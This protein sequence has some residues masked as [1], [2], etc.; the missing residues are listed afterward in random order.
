MV[1]SWKLA[2]ISMWYQRLD[3]EEAIKL[4]CDHFTWD[5]LWEAATEL[6]QHCAARSMSKKI[7]K[8]QDQ[9]DQK[10]RVKIL[11]DGVIN[12]LKEL[13]NKEDC[14]VFVVTSDMLFNVPGVVKDRI[15]VEP[16][17]SA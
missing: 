7:P 11:A 5:E 13:K 6:N 15:Q 3:Q 12:T 16:A 8:N 9:G 2:T 17:V 10:N 4:I 1:D 14:P